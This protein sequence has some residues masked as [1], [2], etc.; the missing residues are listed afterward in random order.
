MVEN[1]DVEDLRCAAPSSLDS[2][3]NIGFQKSQYDL[4]YELGVIDILD[5]IASTSLFYSS[6]EIKK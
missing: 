6:Q 2:G 4:E 3:T 1:Y 5:S